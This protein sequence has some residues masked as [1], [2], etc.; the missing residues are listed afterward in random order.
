MALDVSAL[1]LAL[2]VAL[3]ACPWKDDCDVIEMPWRQDKL[4]S[5]RTRMSRP[6]EKD[7]KLVFAVMKCDSSVQPHPPVQ[8]ALA[9]VTEALSNQGY[10]VCS[11]G[12]RSVSLYKLTR[13]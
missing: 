12:D 11:T 1:E 2:K 7:G 6:G 9:I 3:N 5:I 10:E 13:V 8:R 4:Q